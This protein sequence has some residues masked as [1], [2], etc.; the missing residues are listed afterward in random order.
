MP[1]VP[2]PKP[3]DGRIFWSPPGSCLCSSNAC[4]PWLM[5]E[6]ENVRPQL[7]VCLGASA[8]TAVFGAGFNLMANQ[9]GD[10]RDAQGAERTARMAEH[11]RAM[12]DRGDD[13]AAGNEH[14]LHRVGAMGRIDDAALGNED[15]H[16]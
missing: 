6:I 11:G 3:S 15:V 8:A 12:A 16:A 4:R 14:V 13:L 7:I 5:G 1:L 10:L 2:K 9:T